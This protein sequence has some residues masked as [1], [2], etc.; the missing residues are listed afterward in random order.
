MAVTALALLL[1]VTSASAEII[2]KGTC[3]ADGSKVN[4]TFDSDGTLTVYGSGEMKSYGTYN[5]T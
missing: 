3:G 1:T 2:K 5:A 4:F